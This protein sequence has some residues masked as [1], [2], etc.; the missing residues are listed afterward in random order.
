MPRISAIFANMA[1]AG[2]F[3]ATYLPSTS[4]CPYCYCLINNNELNNMILSNIV[5]RTSQ[6]MQEVI[7]TNQLREFSIHAKFNIFWKFDNFNIYEVTIPDRMHI[8]NLE[9]TKYLLEFMHIYLLQ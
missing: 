5:L 9:N 8:L 6:N 2:A 4:K 7:N 3:T 1:E